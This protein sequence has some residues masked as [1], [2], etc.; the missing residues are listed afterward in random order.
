[1]TRTLRA[2]PTLVRVGLAEAMAYRAELIIW[3][4]TTTMPLVMLPLWQAVAASGP[5]HGFAGADFVAYFLATFVVRQLT[6][7][8][9]SWT[10]H[11]EIRRGTLA[12]RLLRPVH[13]FWA[14]L[15]ENLAALPLRLAVA[16]PFALGALVWTSWDRLEHDPW[17]VM[18]LLPALLGAW[19]LTFAVHLVVGVLCLW[20]QGAIRVMDAWTVGYFVLSGYL[21]PLAV[22]PEPMRAWP[23][24]LPFHFQ[25]GFPV[26]LATGAL[27]TTEALRML[28]EQWLYVLSFT[29][30]CAVLWQRGLARFQA[31]GG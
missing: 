15:I 17:R 20:N 3:I 19:A 10:L 27:G 30:L 12:M 2:L 31:H 24:H 5:V 25:L 11:D 6:S 16:L 1:M 26:E 23:Q 14:Y 8:W 13:P 18:L 7:A 28:G 22:F 21:V 29:A 9:A 4:L